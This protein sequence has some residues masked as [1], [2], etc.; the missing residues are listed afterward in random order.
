MLSK[1]EKL[2]AKPELLSAWWSGGPFSSAI[3]AL[4]LVCEEVWTEMEGKC[5]KAFKELI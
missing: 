4:C 5:L 2:S 1:F 3:W